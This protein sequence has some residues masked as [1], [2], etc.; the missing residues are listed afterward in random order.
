MKILF[1]ACVDSVSSAINAEIAGADRIELCAN[2]LEGGITPS[3][4]TIKLV[5][6]QL[7]IPVNVLVRP[8]SGDF[9]YSDSEF[10]VIKQDVIVCREVGVNGVVIGLLTENGE[11]D[12]FRTKQLIELAGKMSFTFHRAFD[13][14][15]DA[16]KALSLLINLG[17]DRVLTSGQEEDVFKGISTLKKLV[18]L[19]GD[20][21][22]ILPGGGVTENNIKE[23]IKQTGVKEIHASARV[24]VKSRMKFINSRVA[25]SEAN[26]KPGYDLM[27]ASV[28]RI[29]EMIKRISE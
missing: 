11:V 25:M 20:K 14:T 19:A 10:E 3:F 29:R 7:K 22:I 2:L 15:R 9:L 12:Y 28:E 5:V 21:I 13:M 17:V 8:R 24:T 16:E 18:E 1:E 4:A 23:V 6:D 27:V 26:A